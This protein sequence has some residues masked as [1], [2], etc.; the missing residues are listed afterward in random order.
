M[1]AQRARTGRT[2]ANGVDAA[3]EAFRIANAARGGTVKRALGYSAA[4]AA[5]KDS[6][7][8]DLAR[9][10]QDALQRIG[11]LNGL[12]SRAGKA[13][14]RLLD[15]IALL[16]ASR[17]AIKTEISA[18]FPGYSRLID[19]KPATVEQAR[20]SLEPGEA[21]IATMSAKTA[22]T[23]GPYPKTGQVAFNAVDL[24]ARI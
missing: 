6:D 23:S 24:G 21:L 8:A 19:P 14:Q 17:Q 1:L 18:R 2:G 7:L 11:A 13:R 20:L 15:R 4:R 3:R 5:A 10:E 16:K 9:R 12:L 22:P